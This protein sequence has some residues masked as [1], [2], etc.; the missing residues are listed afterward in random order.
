MQTTE[1]DWEWVVSLDLRAVSFLTQKVCRQLLSQ[2]EGGS[3]VNISSVHS[4]SCLPGAGPYD[5]AKWGVCTDHWP[6]P[7]LGAAGHQGIL[8]ATLDQLAANGTLFSQV[9][10]ARTHGDRSFDEHLPMDPE[11]PLMPQVFRDH[12]YRSCAQLEYFSASSVC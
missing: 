8:T 3:I 11:L 12:G 10:T 1:Q 4:V 9:Y 6:G 2:G 5:A 7:L